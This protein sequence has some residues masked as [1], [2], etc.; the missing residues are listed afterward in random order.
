VRQRR[1]GV[2]TVAF[3]G[4]ALCGAL[5]VAAGV[6]EQEESA[7]QTFVGLTLR[8]GAMMG[9]EEEVDS[10]FGPE[11]LSAATA[12]SDPGT[13]AQLRADAAALLSKVTLEEAAHPTPRGVRLLAQ[14]RSFD[15]LL[16]GIGLDASAES[17]EDEAR[18]LYAQSVRRLGAAAAAGATG[19]ATGGAGAATAATAGG[20]IPALATAAASPA[21]S[22]AVTGAATPAAATAVAGAATPAAAHKALS[23]LEAALPGSGPLSQRLADFYRDFVVPADR[24]RVVF[25]RALQECRRRTLT[26]WQL[27]RSEKLDVEWTDSVPA[28]WH[29]YR[30]GWH[31]TLQ[32]NSDAVA[33]PGS[34]IDVACHEA[35]PGHHAQ[36]LLQEQSAQPAGLPVEDRVVLLRS[37]ASVLREG[38]A[39]FGVELAFPFEERVAFEE[40]VLF[41]LAR[42]DPRQARPYET[43]HRLVDQLSATAAPIIAA[44]RDH[45][46]SRDDAEQQLANEALVTSPGALLEFVNHYGAYVLG[47]TAVRDSVRDYVTERSR[48]TA[49]DSWSVLREL[50]ADPYGGPGLT[51]P[52]PQ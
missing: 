35:Y 20:A 18:H 41:P 7:A 2:C 21:A 5:A 42:L 19:P 4:A 12:R 9:H 43:V 22:T 31:S 40:R 8:L 27:P 23:A 3:A 50:V 30:G 45:H 38:A 29:R 49:K 47:Y 48:A 33:L 44:Y 46:L 6:V 10:Y 14:V 15:S 39:N 51:R 1:L 25:Q 11:A 32:I 16:R 36:F 34:A 13:L 52:V 28:A 26:H 24:R 17:F 37:P